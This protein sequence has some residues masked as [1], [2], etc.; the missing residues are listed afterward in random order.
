[1]IVIMMLLFDSRP[2]F[3]VMVLRLLLIVKVNLLLWSVMALEVR[4]DLGVARITTHLLVALVVLKPKM[5]IRLI[6]ILNL[7]A[8]I[9]VALAIRILEVVLLTSS[10]SIGRPA[11][12]ESIRVVFLLGIAASIMLVLPALV[13]LVIILAFLIV[14]CV[15]MLSVDIG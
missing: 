15:A 9:L 1:M 2:V 12:A 13:I 14:E 4:R 10:L 5:V 11:S 7:G 6:V 8:S 3:V